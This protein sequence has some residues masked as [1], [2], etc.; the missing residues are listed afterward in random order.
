MTDSHSTRISDRIAALDR[1][2]KHAEAIPAMLAP[3]VPVTE[4]LPNG[5]GTHRIALDADATEAELNA[6]LKATGWN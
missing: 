5:D 6:A 4:I 3:L 2:I 1:A